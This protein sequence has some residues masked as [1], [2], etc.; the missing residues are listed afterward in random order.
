MTQLLAPS[1]EAV[2]RD[3]GAA[4]EEDLGKGDVSAALLPSG[5]AQAKVVTREDMVLSGSAWASASFGGLDPDVELDWAAQ[6]GD[7]VTAGSTLLTI[8]GNNRAILSAERCALN[9]LQTLSGTATTVARYVS[10]IAHTG[11]K[12]LDTRKT[13]PGLR[14][15]QK[16]AVRCGGGHNHRMG[17]YDA[18]LLKENHLKAAG[19]VAAAVMRARGAFP[20]LPIEVEVETIAQ[21]EACIA[22]SVPRVLLDNFSVEQ[23]AAAVKLSDGRI[24]LES[25]GGHDLES[26][27]A[28]AQTGVHFISVGGLTKHLRATDLSLRF[29]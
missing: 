22:L 19:S 20:S 24:E 2:L 10:T 18:I 29:V 11:C 28:Y 6:D 4:L 15:A 9:F 5:M 16:Y 1:L 13:I 17:L 26:V 25:S 8:K 27:V 12:L 3:V 23:T 21:L 7:R 14:A